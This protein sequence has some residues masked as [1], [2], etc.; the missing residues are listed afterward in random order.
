MDLHPQIQRIRKDLH[1]D[2]DDFVNGIK[3]Y[4]KSKGK[5]K[6]VK[7]IG[8]CC[9][10]IS[11]RVSEE[12]Q[13][14]CD[15]AQRAR[16]EEEQRTHV[17]KKNK[18]YVKKEKWWNLNLLVLAGGGMVYLFSSSESCVRTVSVRTMY[19]ICLVKAEMQNAK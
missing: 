5:K 6:Q 13:R 10:R 1:S 8:H 19:C 9:M 15:E 2:C 11:K 12:E 18:E 14:T 7:H 3:L 16:D 4:Y 17:K